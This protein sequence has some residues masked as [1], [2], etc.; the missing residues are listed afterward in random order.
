[1]EI[2]PVAISQ[3]PSSTSSQHSSSGTNVADKS[4]STTPLSQS[5]HQ[6]QAVK[7]S[8]QGKTDVRRVEQTVSLEE[9]QQI[10]QQELA[11]MVE[12]IEEFVGTLNKGLA[13]RLDEDSGRQ[14]ITV[15]DKKSGEIVRQIPDEDLLSLSRQLATHSGG[16]FTTQV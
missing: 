15:Y 11:K 8:D 12:S 7:S 16:L 2:K 6:E 1:M 4:G 9:K 5:R 10:Q 13:F 3:L 14:I